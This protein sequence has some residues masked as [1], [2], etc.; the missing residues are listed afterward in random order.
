MPKSVEEIVKANFPDECETLGD[1]AKM[2]AR[3]LARTK[4]IPKSAGE[5]GL[6]RSGLWKYLNYQKV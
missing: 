3:S 5:L 6:S 4:S 2:I 1:A